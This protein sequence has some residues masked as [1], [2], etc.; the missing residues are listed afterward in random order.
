M[1]CIRSSRRPGVATSTST[2]FEQRADLGAHRHAADGERRLDAQVA[3]VGAEAVEDLAGSSR[4]G[5]STSTRQVLRLRA[6][7]V[8]GEVIED[9]QREGRG[10]AGAGLGDAD[11]VAPGEQQRDGLGLDRGGGDV[12]LFGEGAKDRLCEAEFVKRVQFK[13]FLY[14]GGP[15]HECERKPN[16]GFE[17]S[18]VDR[19]VSEEKNRK[20]GLK[21][22]GA[23]M[24]KRCAEI[25]FHAARKRP[26]ESSL[27]SD[28]AVHGRL[29][30]LFQGLSAG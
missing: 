3:A 12:F 8:G 23:P 13:V 9:R 10:L 16:A 4:V 28:N 6:R 1:L 7:A 18:R 21:T 27:C 30:G 26:G 19:A 11:D 14:A 20:T 22:S 29:R 24:R 5:L 2:P 17:T 25:V 15:S